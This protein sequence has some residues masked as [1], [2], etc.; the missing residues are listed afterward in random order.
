[1]V[2]HTG[3]RATLTLRAGGQQ[4]LV[5]VFWPPAESH[6]VVVIFDER[7]SAAERWC[8]SL[9]ALVVLAGP[10]AFEL[11]QAMAVVEWTADHAAEM[12]SADGPVAL[13][14]WGA[15]LAVAQAVAGRA[16][17]L[18]WPPLVSTIHK[19]FSTGKE[20]K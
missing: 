13:G 9:G 8:R 6:R 1:M 15:G 18:G 5:R 4:L 12:G 19:D 11:P 3:S 2:S 16:A 14:G 7:T 10:A 17:E 20:Q